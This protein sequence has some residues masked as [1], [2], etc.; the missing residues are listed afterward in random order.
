MSP[1]W[2]TKRVGSS[3][4]RYGASPM[5]SSASSPRRRESP[6]FR[7]LHFLREVGSRLYTG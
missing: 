1:S 3:S 7:P 5:K 6:D 2:L 4:K